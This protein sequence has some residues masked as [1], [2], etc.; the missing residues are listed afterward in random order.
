MHIRHSISALAVLLVSGLAACTPAE[1]DANDPSLVVLV[2]IDQL[3]GD[4][5]NRYEPVF[6]GGFR[7]LLD[8]GMV[9]TGASHNHSSTST[10][11]G[12]TTLATGRFP[13]NHGIVG[14][15]WGE[16]RDDGSIEDV[17]AVRDLDSPILDYPTSEGRSPANIRTDALAD[18]LI[19]ASPDSRTL[20]VSTKDRGAITTAGQSPS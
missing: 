5:V 6:T 18:W 10:A 20:S 19:E 15:S 14:N 17:Y 7:R 9:F 13:A 1:P 12:H 11:I 16:R 8:D 2:T 3:R 4:L